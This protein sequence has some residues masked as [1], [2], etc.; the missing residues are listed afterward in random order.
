[1]SVKS[2]SAAG[3]LPPQILPMPKVAVKAT[4]NDPIMRVKPSGTD[5]FEIRGVA[6][7]DGIIRSTIELTVD[8]K[9][10]SV[11]LMGNATPTDAFLAL[12]KRLPSGYE[13]RIEKADH[14]PGGAVTVRIFHKATRPKKEI[15]KIPTVLVKGPASASVDATISLYRLLRHSH[16]PGPLP[17]G[18]QI[19]A[20]VQVTGSGSD[21]RT[22][23]LKVTEIKF[24]EQG[25][26][27]LVWTFKNPTAKDETRW[28]QRTLSY[29]FKL[30]NTS[31]PSKQYTVVATTGINGAKPEQ[32]RSKYVP[33]RQRH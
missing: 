22:P 1:M 21:D 26:D 11:P 33:V 4:C 25:T 28:G 18:R 32:V 27:K 15:S 8:R 10:V 30:P 17:P 9:K 6:S 16:T 2:L 13:A 31:D 3:V 5:G 19:G 7:N 20:T 23:K 14:E 24:Y 29:N 12:Q